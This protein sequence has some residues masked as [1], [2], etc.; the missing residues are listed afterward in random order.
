MSKEFIKELLQNFYKSKGKEVRYI[1]L[2]TYTTRISFLNKLLKIEKVEDFLIYKDFE[3]VIEVLEKKYKSLSSIT[4]SISS[5]LI[6]LQAVGMGDEDLCLMKYREYLSFT[7]DK[8]NS[9]KY[10]KLNKPSLLKINRKIIKDLKKKMKNDLKKINLKNEI[11]F[12]DKE[13]IQNFLLFSLYTA[14]APVRND[15]CNMK[16]VGEYKDDLD[17]NFN[18]IFKNEDGIYE[19]VF[20][21]YKTVN[22]YGIV[23]FNANTIL[24]KILKKYINYCGNGDYFFCGA[25]GKPYS[26]SSMSQ[27]VMKIFGCG[28]TELRREYLSNEFQILFALNKRI[29][30]VSKRML[31]SRAVIVGNYLQLLQ[32][33]EK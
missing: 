1:T 18:Y 29:T 20:K 12:E 7:Q 4:V 9:E 11:I 5:I 26:K 32:V 17:D 13:T 6:L 23:R 28:I 3:H 25:K 14:Q 31:N 24:N 8:K 22:L 16:I 15:Y 2:L 10:D 19:F 27:K 33:E 21:S 30:D